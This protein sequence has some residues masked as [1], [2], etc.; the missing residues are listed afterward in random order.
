MI[1]HRDYLWKIAF[2]LFMPQ[3]IEFFYPEKYDEIDWVKGI[4]FLDKELNKLIPKSILKNRIA[5]VLVRLYLKSGETVWILLHIEVQGYFD[6]DF[7]LRMHQMCYR[8]EDLFGVT[9]AMLCILTDDDPN[10]IPDHY[11]RITWGSS[12]KTSFRTYKVMKNSPDKY[13]NPDSP[14]SIIMEVAYNATTFKQNSDKNLVKLYLAIVKKLLTK[15]YSKDEVNVLF[16]F[17]SGYVKFENEDYKRIFELKLDN[18]RGYE[19]T[20]QLLENFFNP[21]KRLKLE[22]KWYIEQMVQDAKEKMERSV[23]LLLSN[24]IKAEI[25]SQNLNLTLEEIKAIENKFKIKNIS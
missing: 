1:V 5:D 22:K 14:I 21:R 3:F 7:A 16:S 15:G 11:E 19:T 25:I 2:R 20:E 9:P 10:F 23:L 18:M 4:E 13:L 24:G 12:H 6:A 8:I 17:I